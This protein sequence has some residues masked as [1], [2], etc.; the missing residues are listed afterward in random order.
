[1]LKQY[2]DIK[3]TGLYNTE[4]LQNLTKHAQDS[5]RMWN[6]YGHVV[7]LEPSRVTHLFSNISK[8][9]WT[10]SFLLFSLLFTI[11]NN[12]LLGTN[13]KSN[14]VHLSQILLHNL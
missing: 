3:S 11:S 12:V 5:G 9:R 2:P 14:N 8:V 13:T 4:S 1:M 6:G 7:S 10:A